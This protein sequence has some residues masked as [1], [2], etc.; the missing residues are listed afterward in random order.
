MNQPAKSRIE[1]GCDCGKLRY[2][3]AT[4]PMFVHCC[5]CSWCQRESGSAF[6]LNALIETDRVELL[7]G[8]PV[9]T[10]LP[11]AS[12]KGQTVL[13]CSDCGV[14]LWSHFAGAGRAMAFVRIGTLEEP[15]RFP[16]DV[17]I[18]TST[19]LPWVQLPEGVPVFEGYYAAKEVWPE[20]CQQ[21]FRAMKQAAQSGS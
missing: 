5:H 15:G 3:L 11:T 18:F 10:E 7:E 4:E 1:G 14:T 16:P 2:R 8:E 21:R 17:H 6:A 20:A 9:A 12:G 13:R 19:R